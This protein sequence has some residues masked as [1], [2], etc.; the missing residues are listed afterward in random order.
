MEF[1][2][3]GSD[4]YIIKDSCGVV[5]DEKEKKQ[6]EK[7]DNILKDIISNECQETRKKKRNKKVIES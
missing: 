4:K 3:I 2:K 1:I 5:V 6:L 7:R